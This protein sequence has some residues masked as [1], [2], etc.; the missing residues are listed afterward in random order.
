MAMPSS[1]LP[2][3]A[4][5]FVGYGLLQPFCR[6]RGDFRAGTGLD[7]LTSNLRQILQTEPGEI[8]WAPSAGC[9]LRRYKNRNLDEALVAAIREEVTSA[10]ASQDPR[11]AV[12]E[13][14]AQQNE[15]NQLSVHIAAW[16]LVYNQAEASGVRG[17]ALPPIV[18][19]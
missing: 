8:P 3:T 2:E 5:Q 11:I 7:L 16:A 4:R 10:I 12:T 18:V 19:G 17:T 9:H 13:V 15:D 14:A 6:A 1:P